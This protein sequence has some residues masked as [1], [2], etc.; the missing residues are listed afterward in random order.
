MHD[1][2]HGAGVV[3]QSAGQHR[4][5]HGGAA[6]DVTGQP[7]DGVDLVEARPA[8]RG[9]GEALADATVAV[10]GA[11]VVG[12]RLDRRG[13]DVPV[14]ELGGDAVDADLVELVERDQ[15]RRLELVRQ[16]VGLDEPAESLAGVELDPEPGQ[17]ERVQHVGDGH[18][19][20]C[21]GQQRIRAD[22]VDVALEELA[23]ATLA[24]PVCPPHGRDLVALERRRQLRAVARDH[25]G[26]RHREVVA[27]RQV[28]LAGTPPA[29]RASG[30][31]R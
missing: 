25:A 5:V 14:A 20:G 21:V 13:R 28:R 26:E 18:D 15:D 6:R 23:V 12:Q 3:R 4:R 31:G 24:G 10:V 30:C 9:R 29:H 7:E 1:L 11:E 19:G 2:E 8:T 17:A 22:R 16:A 27:E